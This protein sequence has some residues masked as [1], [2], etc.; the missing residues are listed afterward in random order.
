MP[1]L[2]LSSNTPP[3]MLIRLTYDALA[4]NS[5]DLLRSKSELSK[6]MVFG[7]KG[8]LVAEILPSGS[9]VTSASDHHEPAFRDTEAIH[10]FQNRLVMFSLT[11]SRRG[12]GETVVR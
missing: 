1:I 12:R 7:A 11:T 6:W 4:E 9:F 10:A 3:K 5:N 2:L 8:M